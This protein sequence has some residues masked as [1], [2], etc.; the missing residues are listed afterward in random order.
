MDLPIETHD[1]YDV[2]WTWAAWYLRTARA[3]GCEGEVRVEPLEAWR[4]KSEPSDTW[5]IYLT[6][7]HV[8]EGAGQRFVDKLSVQYAGG[9]YAL[10]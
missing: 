9:R 10:R 4:A 8:P 1:D 6:L 5:G 2:A 7:T 3:E